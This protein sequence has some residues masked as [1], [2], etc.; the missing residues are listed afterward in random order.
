MSHQSEMSELSRDRRNNFSLM[1]IFF[2]DY[3]ASVNS[4]MLKNLNLR[5]TQSVHVKF[6]L[7]SFISVITVTTLGVLVDNTNI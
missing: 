3:I 5:I 7:Q 6:T 4:F 2:Y 1:G